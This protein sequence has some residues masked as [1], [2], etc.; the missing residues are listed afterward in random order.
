MA[1]PLPS[2]GGMFG[3]DPNMRR[4]IGNVLTDFGGGLLQGKNF[5]QGLGLGAQQM[6]QM[7]PYRD[8]Q[9]QMV[10]QQETQAT[11]TNATINWLKSKG[12]D[13]LVAAVGGGLPIGDAW[14]EGLKRANPAPAAPKDFM[15][16]ADGASIWDPNTQTMVFENPKGQQDPLV[17]N[18]IGGT[19]K[20]YETLDAKSAE[21][22]AALIDAGMNARSNNI[23]LT[24]IENHLANAPQGIEGA[25]TQVVG[26]LGIPTEGLDDVQAAQALINQMVPGQRVPG[27]G[28]MSD[29]DLALF[30]A[31]LPAIVNQPGGNAYI[32]AT[33]K[34]IND[35]NI[36]LADIAT[37][38]ANREISPAEGRAMQAAVPNPLN[39]FKAGG[40]GGSGDQPDAGGWTDM[41]GGIRVRRK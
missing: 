11:Q 29:A 39:D 7:Q 6:A 27:S 32:I 22:Q 2:I 37:Q 38:V 4:R 16:V 23:R 21:A 17:V 18:N 24:Q 31:S 35:Y 33:A 1:A 12:Y 28:T 15:N 26:S 41:G 40:L 20:F 3:L 10:A 5:Q 13:D 25:M 8:Q 14:Q 30:K 36:Q 9:E 19:D 34:A